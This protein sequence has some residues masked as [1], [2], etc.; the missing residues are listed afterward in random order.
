MKYVDDDD[1]FAAM[2]AC[3]LFVAVLLVYI[4]FSWAGVI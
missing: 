3:L 4:G 2:Y 1:A